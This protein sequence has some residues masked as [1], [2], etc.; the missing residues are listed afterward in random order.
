MDRFGGANVTTED[1]QGVV[2]EVSGQDL[3]DFFEAWL[4][5]PELPEQPTG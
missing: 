1:Y 5:D 3:D 4:L 2:E